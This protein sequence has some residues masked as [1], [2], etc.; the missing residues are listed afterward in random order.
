MKSYKITYKKYTEYSSL[1]GEAT[2]EL[3]VIP[4]NGY[5]QT[6]TH[7]RIESSLEDELFTYKNKYDS[8]VIRIRTVKPFSEFHFSL[9]SLVN[10]AEINPFDF[11][12]PEAV[13]D[14]EVIQ[15]PD[16]KINYYPFLRKTPFTSTSKEE[17]STMPQFKKGQ[18]VFDYLIEL[19]GTIYNNLEFCTESTDVYSTAKDVIKLKRGVCQDFSHLF[20]AIARCNGI[21]ARYVSGYLSQGGGF[22]GDAFMHSWIEAYVPKIGWKGFDP[23]NNLLCESN[24]IKVAHGVDYTEC[25]PIKGIIISTGES[26]TLS[27]DYSVSVSTLSYANLENAQQ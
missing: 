19:N 7:T 3:L 13:K 10:K 26:N 22:V 1:I 6:V 2:Y 9:E 27:S 24:Y 11:M 16:F 20:I 17:C 4:K 14:W 8:D 18:R 23:T 12:L 5:T 21:P 25:A 15:S